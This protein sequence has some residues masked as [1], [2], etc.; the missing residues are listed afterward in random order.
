MLPTYHLLRGQ[1]DHCPV[2]AATR[3][4]YPDSAARSVIEEQ[5]SRKH[6]LVSSK[7]EPT[8]NELSYISTII[9]YQ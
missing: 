4:H 5:A 6:A 9:P 8:G 7:R 2:G 3:L 1:N